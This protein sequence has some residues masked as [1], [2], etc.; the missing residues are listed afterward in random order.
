[1]LTIKAVTVKAAAPSVAACCRRSPRAR[2]KQSPVWTRG[3]S[4]T[5][6]DWPPWGRE[7]EEAGG[8]RRL[9]WQQ[10]GGSTVA[11]GGGGLGLRARL[12]LQ[13]H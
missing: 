9:T 6:G 5:Q 3:P 1:M 4:P 8:G 10:E 11:L 13:K 12:Y 7:V 2:L